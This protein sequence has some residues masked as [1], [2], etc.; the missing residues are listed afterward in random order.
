[1]STQQVSIKH[2]RISVHVDKVVRTKGGGR[3]V[4]KVRNIVDNPYHFLLEPLKAGKSKLMKYY[5]KCDFTDC[6][7]A[8]TFAD[9][10]TKLNLFEQCWSKDN[11]YLK[12]AKDTCKATFNHYYMQPPE[13]EATGEKK[14]RASV[15]FK[16][17]KQD[18]PNT[19]TTK[20]RTEYEEYLAAPREECLTALEYWRRYEH[21][22][23]TV[24]AIAKDYL[25]ISC[26]SVFLE[27]QFKHGPDMV[28]ANRNR[29]KPKTIGKSFVT[30]KLQAFLTNNNQSINQVSSI[31]E[32][33]LECDSRFKSSSRMIT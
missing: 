16:G 32:L 7:Y 15:F 9:P 29:L 2:S 33:E 4:T 13:T 5:V 23:P 28:T 1:M 12:L 27:R 11:D 18:E 30:R 6:Y 10:T 8:A 26:S 3:K 20:S 21:L 17:S 19:N 25:A 24:A 31:L 22:Y 14:N